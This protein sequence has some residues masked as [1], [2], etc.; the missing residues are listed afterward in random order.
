MP[1]GRVR[2]N[3]E[4]MQTAINN[5]KTS[6]GETVSTIF[7]MSD[8]VRTMDQAWDGTASERFKSQFNTMFNNLRQCEEKVD[9][10][11]T[12]LEG[13]LSS[14]E[15]TEVDVQGLFE[16]LDEGTAYSNDIRPSM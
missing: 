1:D 7:K 11:I 6:K 16:D 4:V 14:Y 10:F 3:K 9:Q 2:I 8:A 13:V 15:S 12:N 5:Y